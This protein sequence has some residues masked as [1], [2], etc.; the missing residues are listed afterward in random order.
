M[1]PVGNL[2]VPLAVKL[3]GT[4]TKELTTETLS[5][6]LKDLVPSLRILREVCTG[7][8]SLFARPSMDIDDIL[9]RASTMRHH[10]ITLPN[11]LYH[12]LQFTVQNLYFMVAKLKG[13]FPGKEF[14]VY[15]TGSDQLEQLLS[16]V[17]THNH[18]RN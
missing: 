1:N 18:D 5:P 13:F 9:G 4:V 15:Q 6:G 16:A 3:H 12:D 7:L 8:L 11:V 17:R 2:K 14:Y 10:D